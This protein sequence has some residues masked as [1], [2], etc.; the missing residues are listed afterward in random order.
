MGKKERKARKAKRK[1]KK[2]LGQRVFEGVVRG[3]ANLITSG[4]EKITKKKYGRQTKDSSIFDTKAGKV[5][6][7][8]GG[9]S[10]IATGIGIIGGT[11]VGRKAVGKILIPKTPIGL[12]T[13]LGLGGVLA[14]SSKARKTFVNLPESTFKAGEEIGKAYEGIGGSKPNGNGKDPYLTLLPFL[15]GL[16]GAGAGVVGAKIFDKKDEILQTGKG[17]FDS[18]LNKDILPEITTPK[19]AP[20]NLSPEET[21]EEI[22]KIPQKEMQ[23]AINIK[24]TNKPQNNIAI[25]I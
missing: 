4:I 15:T 1:A 19:S 16:F 20:V 24:I 23:P 7:K 6:G 5:L 2:G 12:L 9:I 11:A 10:T 21:P 25:A 17:L 13:R 3:G 18:S 22:Q 14:T 8:A